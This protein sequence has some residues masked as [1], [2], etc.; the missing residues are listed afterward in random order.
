MEK[1]EQEPEPNL[2]DIF[3]MIPLIQH[4]AG[5]FSS[6]HPEHAGDVDTFLQELF[7]IKS[8]LQS[9]VYARMRMKDQQ[10]EMF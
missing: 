9:A 8:E 3:N 10:R 4:H 7:R 2:L 5:R 1:Q 6:A